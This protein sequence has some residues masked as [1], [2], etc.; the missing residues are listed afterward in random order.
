MLNRVIENSVP[1]CHQYWPVRANDP[2][3]Y[4]DVGLQ[5][6][7]VDEHSQGFYIVRT[8]RITKLDTD[9]SRDV[10]QFHYTTWPDFSVPASPAAFL[11]FLAAV[12]A[13]DGFVVDNLR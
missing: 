11:N 10:L 13:S 1:K 5:I 9:E 8:L 7:L 6:S 2:I 12:R 4:D 3:V